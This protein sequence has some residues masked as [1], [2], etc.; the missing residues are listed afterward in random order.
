MSFWFRLGL[1]Y[2]ELQQ[3]ENLD[4]FLI[5]LGLFYATNNKANLAEKLYTESILK[6][7]KAQQM[8]YPL[9]MAKNLLG[10]LLARDEKREDEAFMHL[11]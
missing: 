7:E 2:H 9:M 3:P 1:R 4:R 11:K 6:M 5:L 10:R 8:N